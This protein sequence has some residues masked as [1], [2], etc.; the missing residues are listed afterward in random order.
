MVFVS[1]Y[2]RLGS[3][4][5]KSL[6]IQERPEVFALEDEEENYVRMH[7]CQWL[8]IDP[9]ECRIRSP[10]QYFCCSITCLPLPDAG[11]GGAC[12]LGWGRSTY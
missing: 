11:I 12:G 1:S 8:L 6:V 4:L 9:N 2:Q 7:C 3:S 10:Q 5:E